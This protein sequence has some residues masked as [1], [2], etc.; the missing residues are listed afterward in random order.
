MADRVFTTSNTMADRI[1]A[2]EVENDAGEN[3]SRKSTKVAAKA[4]LLVSEP[5]PVSAFKSIE[6]E[7]FCQG[8]DSLSLW[9]VPAGYVYDADAQSWVTELPTVKT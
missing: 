7:E 5:I 4:N 8:N 3:D 6:A 1:V 9:L 2:T